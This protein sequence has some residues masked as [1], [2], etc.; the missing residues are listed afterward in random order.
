MR[1][2][3]G[4][5]RDGALGLAEHDAI[6]GPVAP[7]GRELIDA[8]AAAGLRG[9]GGAGFPTAIKLAAVAEGRRPVVV[10]ATAP[11]ASRS[12]PRTGCC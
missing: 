2:L 9:R 7:G 3:T 4:L 12:A 11:R 1:L 6:H 8:V 10:V 5:R